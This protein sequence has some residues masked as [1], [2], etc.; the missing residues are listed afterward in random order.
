M[1]NS[2]WRLIPLLSA[3]GSVQMAIDQWLLETASSGEKSANSAILHLATGGDFLGLPPAQVA[4]V[5]AA[6]VLGGNACAV[7]EEA[8][9]RARGTSPRGFNLCSCGLGIW[10]QS[11][12]SL[13]DYLRVFD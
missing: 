11:Y 7:G 4:G 2:V 10:K 1:A 9:R 12:E 8:Q 13:S 6:F 5:L 3:S